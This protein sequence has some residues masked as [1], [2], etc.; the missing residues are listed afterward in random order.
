MLLCTIIVLFVY[1]GFGWEMEPNGVIPIKK[2]VEESTTTLFPAVG[3]MAAL[4][5]KDGSICT[6][7][8]NVKVCLFEEVNFYT[9]GEQMQFGYFEGWNVQQNAYKE[10]VFENGSECLYGKR[11]SSRVVMEERAEI[12]DMDIENINFESECHLE[13]TLV[14][15]KGY[16]DLSGGI[17][18]APGVLRELPGEDL[19]PRQEIKVVLAKMEELKAKVRV[20]NYL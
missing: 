16:A 6:E 17:L 8:E 2:A 4:F 19:E 20:L 13:L 14:L 7:D 15:P 9:A 1:H 11:R 10:M 12:L 5:Q 18:G 3:P